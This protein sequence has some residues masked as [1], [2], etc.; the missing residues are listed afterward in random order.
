[1]A[2]QSLDPAIN[3]CLVAG[4]DGVFVLSERPLDGGQ[5]AGYLLFADLHGPADAVV[6]VAVDPAGCDEIGTAEEQAA[7]LWAAQARASV[8]YVDVRSEVASEAPE[9]GDEGDRRGGIDD[10]RHATGAGDVNHDVNRHRSVGIVA[11]G[12]PEDAGSALADG[13]GQIGLIRA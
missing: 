12:K 3:G 1:N 9:V 2:G 7:G 11:A 8:Q 10:D 6:R 5:D 4:E 13:D